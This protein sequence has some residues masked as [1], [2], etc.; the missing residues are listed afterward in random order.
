[1]GQ[2]TEIVVG[3]FPNVGGKKKKDFVIDRGVKKGKKRTQHGGGSNR[4]EKKI[5][6]PLPPAKT[7]KGGDKKYG[8]RQVSPKKKQAKQKRVDGKI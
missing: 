3:V 7:D 6:K 8:H 5:Q 1:M 2:H 4:Q